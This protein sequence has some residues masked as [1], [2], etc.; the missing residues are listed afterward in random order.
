MTDLNNDRQEPIQV[1][2]LLRVKK[3]ERPDT[4]FWNRFDRELHQRMLQTLVRKE[5]WYVQVGRGLSGRF[6]QSAAVVSAAA[7]LA[8]MVV[9][10]A[11]V[12]IEPSRPGQMASTAE[13]SENA[14][15]A[16]QSDNRAPREIDMADFNSAVAQ[17]DY[18][19]EVISASSDDQG[20]RY[21][22][23]FQMDTVQVASS[24]A[25]DYSGDSA[26]SWPT[27]GNTGVASLVY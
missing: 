16:S 9:R 8:I 10:P 19:I 20:M 22:R 11:F 4:A 21:R 5:P 27:F 7:L 12:A 13:V 23:D 3:A 18:Q 26:G 17:A 24:D 6:A 1:E 25:A 15:A 2:D 14:V